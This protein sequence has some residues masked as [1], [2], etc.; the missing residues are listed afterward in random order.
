MTSASFSEEPALFEE[1]ALPVARADEATAAVPVPRL[2]TT[3]VLGWSLVF[4]VVAIMLARQPL[5]PLRLVW[6]LLLLAL[7]AALYLGLTLRGGL[8]RADLTPRG[9]P[10]FVVRRRLA[11]LAAMALLVVALSLLVPKGGMWWLVMHAI[12]AAGLALSAAWA[13]GVTV[14]LLVLAVGGQWLLAGRIEALL[15]IQIAFGAGAIAIRELTI[16]VAQLRAAREQLARLAVAEERLR[17]GRDLHDLLGHTLSSIVLKTELARRLLPTLP[18][19][20]SAELADIEHAA[21]EALSEVRATVAGYRQPVLSSELSAARELLE[22]ACISADIVDSAGPLPAAVDALLAWAVREGVTNVIRH[23]GALRCAI[24]VSLAGDRARVE[25][26]DDGRGVSGGPPT[27][28]SGLAGLAERA[29][30]NAGE[31]EAGPRLEGG[32]SLAVLAPLAG[33]ASRSNP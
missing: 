6:A 31:L 5:S 24:T 4:G 1:E 12:V 7:L 11:V 30:R 15:L 13:A 28:G 32:F 29:S 14:A 21:R 10:T 33:T 26:A 3:F 25:V 23:S 19:R 8:T 20:A 16:T 2:W 22:L 27:Y 9:P 18:E 17:F